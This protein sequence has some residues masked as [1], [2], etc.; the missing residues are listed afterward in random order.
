MS[1][2]TETLQKEF[3]VAQVIWIAILA[4]LVI[5]LGVGHVFFGRDFVDA[6][7]VPLSLIRNILAGVGGLM[8]VG[9]WFIRRSMLVGNGSASPPDAAVVAANYRKATMISA[10]ICEA[11]GLFGLVLVFLGD[12]L[13]TLYLF[14]VLATAAMII[15]R[16]KMEELQRLAG[17]PGR[18]M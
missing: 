2:M 11:V 18:A 8:L 4:A 16:P 1:T 12:S 5:Y 15:Q 10:G 7:T 6:E 3:R 14:V 13:Q 17:G 9:S